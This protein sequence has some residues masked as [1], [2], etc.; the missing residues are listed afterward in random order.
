MKM[1]EHALVIRNI[2][3]I[4]NGVAGIVSVPGQNIG[5]NAR[6]DVRE[7]HVDNGNCAV[8]VE[9]SLDVPP[10][11]FSAAVKLKRRTDA[12]GKRDD[13][14]SRDRN[15]RQA[16][17]APLGVP[18]LVG[19]DGVVHYGA[20]YSIWQTCRSRRSWG[21]YDG[22][23]GGM[24]GC[25]PPAFLARLPPSRGTSAPV[26]NDDASEASRIARPL[27]SSG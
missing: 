21:R 15:R 24:P 7:Q 19:K 23:S 16:A 25:D 1:K 8:S 9:P 10:L 20:I 12:L 5:A 22:P 3:A 2:I 18:A 4:W 17:E 6:G 26:M 14:R 27:I 13:A 11:E